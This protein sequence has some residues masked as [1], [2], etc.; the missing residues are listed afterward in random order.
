MFLRLLKLL[1]KKNI[2]KNIVQ[3]FQNFFLVDACWLR[4]MTMDP[5]I[6]A[7]INTVPG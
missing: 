4:E 1:K 6:L 2:K 3:C 7:H 5:H